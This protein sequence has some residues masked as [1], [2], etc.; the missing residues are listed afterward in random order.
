MLTDADL[1]RIVAV[2][3]TKEDV[4]RIEE[5][6]AELRDNL[7][8]FVTASEKFTGAFHDL[9]LEYAAVSTQLSR[10]EAWIKQLAEKAGVA[11]D[12]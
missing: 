2:V 9:K 1:A 7:N 4:R 11:L 5:E 3:A 8:R 10:H 12:Y 6:V